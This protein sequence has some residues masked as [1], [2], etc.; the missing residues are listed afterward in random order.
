M[1]LESWRGPRGQELL[2]FGLQGAHRGEQGERIV[3]R[4]RR[5]PLTISRKHTEPVCVGPQGAE[6]PSMRVHGLALNIRCSQV[7]RERL[8]IHPGGC[9]CG[10]DLLVN[11]PCSNLH[12]PLL[13]LPKHR[14]PPPK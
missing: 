12:N 2:M 14:R 8:P 11:D 4:I 9:R 7:G 1:L 3:D 13:L 5:S 6:N 10:A